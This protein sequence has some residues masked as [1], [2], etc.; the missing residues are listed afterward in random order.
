MTSG[1]ER[2]FEDYVPGEYS[3]ET[4]EDPAPKAVSSP[5]SSSKPGD[6][7]AP[8]KSDEVPTKSVSHLIRRTPIRD[9]WERQS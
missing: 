9:P 1:I 6:A 4:V 5:S 2:L 8:G 7:P 3:S